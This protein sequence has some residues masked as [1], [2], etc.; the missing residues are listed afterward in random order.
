MAWGQQ[1]QEEEEGT[2]NQ[3]TQSHRQP[4]WTATHPEALPQHSRTHSGKVCRATRP[5]TGAHH[6][7][8]QFP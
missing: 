5:N 1:S 2:E 3:D 8:P 7:V 6:T 4:P